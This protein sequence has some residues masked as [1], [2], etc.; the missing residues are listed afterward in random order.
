[1]IINVPCLLYFTYIDPHDL[2]QVVQ[3]TPE[4]E[5]LGVMWWLGNPQ[6]KIACRTRPSRLAICYQQEHEPDE[7]APTNETPYETIAPAPTASKTTKP[8][9][10]KTTEQSKAITARET[11]EYFIFWVYDALAKEMKK[12]SCCCGAN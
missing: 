1:M 3:L 11:R 10:G 8:E 9:K 4:L 2:V 5:R 7:F 12:N 6:L